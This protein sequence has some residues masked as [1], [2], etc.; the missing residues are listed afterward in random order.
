MGFGKGMKVF[1]SSAAVLKHGVRCLLTGLVILV[2]GGCSGSSGIDPEGMHE[3]STLSPSTEV[4]YPA[5]DPFLPKRG[6]YL[7][8]ASLIPPHADL[9][10]AYLKAGRAADFVNLWVGSEQVGYWN[11]AEHLGGGWGK[12]FLENFTRGN[13][14]FPIINLSF[15]DREPNT[16]ALVL[17]EPDGKEYRGLSDPD[18]QETYR[19]GALN[20]VRES[21]PL[22]ISLGNE[23][24]RW[25]EEYGADP[26]DPDGFQHYVRLYEETYRAVKTLSPETKVFCIFARE[27]VSEQR[28][29][30]LQALSMFDPAFLDLVVFTSYPFAVAEIRDVN[31]LPDDYYS[32]ALDIL[33]VS[34][35]PFGFTET[36][37]SAHQGFGGEEAQAEFL[38]QLTSRLT[39]SRGLELKLLGWWSLYDL[40]DSPHR[41]GLLTIEGEE[42]EVY[43]VWQMLGR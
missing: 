38:R 39:I 26:G 37:W 28:Q 11:L 43:E 19:Q 29:A 24:N 1:I 2:L 4:I 41:L 42:K 17:K 12:M 8:F 16:G 31:D 5:D 18:F 15:M 32:R 30:D 7:G 10:D 27:I 21:K 6:Y 14:M 9:K 34:G 35:K 25:Y 13:G 3:A 33:G 20:A 23:V 40:E 22:Y 36:A